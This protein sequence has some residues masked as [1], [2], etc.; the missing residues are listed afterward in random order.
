MALAEERPDLGVSVVSPGPVDTGFFADLSEVSDLTF[1]Q[2]MSSADAVAEQIVACARSPRRE[3]AIPAMSG[4]LTTLGYFAPGLAR[5]LRPGLRRRGAKAKAA[6]AAR[7]AQGD[8][9]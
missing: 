1:S 3:V 8:A 5:A 2:P 4:A 9:Q 7:R 6:Y